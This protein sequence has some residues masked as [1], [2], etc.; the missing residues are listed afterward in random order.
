MVIVHASGIIF[1]SLMANIFMEKFMNEIAIA[2]RKI[3]ENYPPLVI[4]EIGI[5]HGGDL[6]AAIEMVDSAVSAGVEVIK[7]QTHIIEDEMSEEA[8]LIIPGNAKTSIYE[9]MQRCALNEEDEYKL[10]QYTNQKGAIF[11]STPFLTSRN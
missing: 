1:Y 9:I 10:M 8:K 7:H 5:N 6:D 3:G 11:I 4:A 2:G